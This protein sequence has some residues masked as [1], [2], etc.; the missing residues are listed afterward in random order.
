MITN[1][2]VKTRSQQSWNLLDQSVRSHEG[3]IL[4]CKLLDLLLVLVQLL[5]VVGRHG[6][7]AQGLSLVNVLLISQQTDLVLQLWNMLQPGK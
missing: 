4:G 3:V 6:V 7:H 2:L 1:Y 5:E